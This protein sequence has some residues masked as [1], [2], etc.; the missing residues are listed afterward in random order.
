MTQTFIGDLQESSNITSP[1]L[2]KIKGWGFA[3]A[4]FTSA[5]VSLVSFNIICDSINAGSIAAGYNSLQTAS[6]LLIL[7]LR[8]GYSAE[9]VSH[10]FNAWG[11]DGIVK[12]LIIELIDVTLYHYGYR[13]LF[14][15]LF[16]RLGDALA[17][18]HVCGSAAEDLFV[19]LSSKLSLCPVIVAGTDFFEDLAQVSVALSFLALTMGNGSA[20]LQLVEPFPEW[21]VA[22]VSIASWLNVTKWLMVRIGSLVGLLGVL[23]LGGLTAMDKLQKED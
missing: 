9:T 4:C 6:D 10:L 19:L 3:G 5:A 14:V 18:K 11:K 23:S 16:N 21:W 20:S 1:V 13:G 15:V 12:Y 8:N 2:N 7:D 22:L 17:S